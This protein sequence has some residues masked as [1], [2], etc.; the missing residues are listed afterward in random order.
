MTEDLGYVADNVPSEDEL[1]ELAQFFKVFGDT[2]RIRILS[3]L[4]I[5]ELCVC[6]LVSLL[7]MNQPAV[8]HQ[9][10]ILRAAKIVKNRKQGKHVFYSLDDDHVHELLKDGL[11]HIRGNCG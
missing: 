8:S 6:D 3:A 5:R 11:E 9:L 2:T 4:Y 7:D 10:R 1:H